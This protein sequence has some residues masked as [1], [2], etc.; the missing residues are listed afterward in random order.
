VIE[1]VAVGS[2]KSC[3]YPG[4]PLVLESRVISTTDISD[5]LATDRDKVVY[6]LREPSIGFKD[7][8]LELDLLISTQ[9][10]VLALFLTQGVN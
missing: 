6:I 8:T 5:L 3:R 2:L 9:I 10:S 4:N 1:E 7:E